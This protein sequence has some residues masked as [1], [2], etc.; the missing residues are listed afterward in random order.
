MKIKNHQ[1]LTKNG[2]TKKLQKSRNIALQSLQHALTAV[3]PKQLLKA[4]IKIEKDVLQVEKCRF[5]LAEFR[6]I[7]VVGGGKASGKMA[8]ALEELLGEYLTSGA[9][10]VPYGEKCETRKVLLQEASH[11]VPDQNGVEA[12]KRMMALA[13]AAGEADLVVCLISGGGSSLMPSPRDVFP[14]RDKQEITSALLKSGAAIT[15][16]NIV[17]KHL[18]NLKG[19]WLP[20]KRTLQQF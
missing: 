19:G 8:Q 2:Q 20:K 15:Q 4:K 1:Q 5:N 12:T 17:R 3:E 16:V 13:G 7:Y 11:P 14:C 18:S 6:H 10:N 9:V